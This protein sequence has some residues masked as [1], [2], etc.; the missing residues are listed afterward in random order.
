MTT[1]TNRDSAAEENHGMRALVASLQ[2]AIEGEVYSSTVKRAGYSTDASNYRVVPQV[3]VCPKSTDDITAAM[4]VA[5]NHRVPLTMR[6]GGTSTAGNS[7]ST[8]VVL[9]CSRHLNHILA[10][11]PVARTALVEPGVV[12]SQ[13]QAAAEPHGLRFGPDPSTQNRCTI[14]GM[15][16][17]NACGPHA[18]TMGRTADNALSLDVLDGR[19]RRFTAGAGRAAIDLVPGLGELV[20]VNEA[21][22]RTTFGQFI[23][24]VSGYSME[25]LLPERGQDMAKFLVGSENTLVT[26]LHATV[27]L[28]PV[29]CK[30]VLVVLGYPDMPTAADRVIPLLEMRPMAVEGLDS[31]LLEHVRKA[32][33][34]NAV[35]P[36]P[37]GQAWLMIEVGAEPDEAQE[38]TLARARRLAE[39]G[40]AVDSVVLPSGPDADAL[41]RIRA[42]GAGL[43]GRTPRDTPA[44]PMWEDSAVP[45]DRLGDYLRS[46]NEL[47]ARYDYDGLMFGHFGDG[48]VHVR[49]DAP[50]HDRS[51]VPEWKRFI[52]EC[53]DLC[54]SYGGSLSGEHGDGR[55]RSA[56]LGRMYPPEAL[57]LF[58]NVK[59]LFDPDINLNPHVLVDPAPIDAD[60][61]RPHAAASPRFPGGFRFPNDH[62]DLTC[63]VHRCTG[64]GKC[65]A[66]L[67]SSGGFMCP[68]YQATRDEK[69]VTRGRARVLQEAANGS[70]VAGWTDHAVR[71]ALD[72]CLS[73]KACSTDCPTGMDMARYKSEALHRTYRGR[74]RPRAH[75]LLGR[76]PMW[77]GLL[78]RLPF[79]PQLANLFMG[80]GPLRKMVFALAG[81]D[82]RRLMPRIATQTFRS[83]LAKARSRSLP[84]LSAPVAPPASRKVVLWADSFSEDLDARGAMAEVEL[85]ETAGYEVVIPSQHVCCG[86][87]WISTGQLDGARRKL[88]QLLDVLVPYAAN[89]I[90]IIG[91]EPSCTAVLRDDL[92]DLL[93]DDP[94]ASMLSA[95][96]MTLAELLTAP[97]PVGP[98]SQWSPPDLTGLEVVAQP[99]CH[100][101]SV[102]GWAFDEAL[103]QRTGAT[104][105]KLNGCCG[106][107]GNFGMEAGHYE[108]SVAVAENSLLPKLAMYPDAVF[109]ADG[110]SCRTQA[111]QLASRGGVHLAELLHYGRAVQFRHVK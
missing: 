78:Q 108:V 50:L 109:L 1:L 76:L 84:R 67:S 79:A 103:L 56:L 18:M 3:V 11:D 30:P 2:R 49:I 61:R 59:A 97:D 93:P 65:R 60:L 15:I 104:L 23:R 24:Q 86:L 54:S 38:D 90:P 89:G 82:P 96:V 34:S 14:G 47:M 7:L 13:L 28:V 111:E 26:V 58:A 71:E 77:T 40:D 101:Y 17:N 64:V 29:P 70:L 107:A 19:G 36:V 66:D 88:T 53:A 100:H 52:E 27:G 22:I 95:N 41:W 45:P 48:C 72:L 21:F 9:D 94:R 69:N 4:A 35:P 10:L 98:G 62:D 74:M 33:G 91:V 16:G 75:Y 44:W 37:K 43:A 80:V 102:M 39:A 105:H 87:T 81:I 73:C 99:H 12:M 8:G 51:R 5:R 46:F 85:L 32:K 68:S 31:R 42:D 57:E 92:L 55:N 20:E 83:T 25:W 63:A 110:F 106:L 6:G